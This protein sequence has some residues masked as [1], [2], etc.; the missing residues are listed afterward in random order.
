VTKCYVT[1]TG[2]CAGRYKLLVDES[3]Q[4]RPWLSM[5]HHNGYWGLRR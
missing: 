1:L 4:N 5:R 2:D 3:A